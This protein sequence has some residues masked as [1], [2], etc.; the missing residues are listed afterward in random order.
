MDK[1]KQRLL[2][3]KQTYLKLEKEWE[4][5][6]MS[7]KKGERLIQEAHVKIHRLYQEYSEAHETV[8]KAHRTIADLEE[9]YVKKLMLE[10]KELLKRLEIA[11]KFNQTE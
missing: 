9:S 8:L 11:E 3:Q 7:Q 2:A 10:K 4:T 5:L 1:N 6:N